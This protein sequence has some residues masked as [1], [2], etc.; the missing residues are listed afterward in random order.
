MAEFEN[1]D[2]FVLQA[3]ERKRG[4]NVTRVQEGALPISRQSLVQGLIGG[5]GGNGVGDR[6]STLSS[7]SV[8]AA[9]T[10]PVALGASG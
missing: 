2:E 7:R 4:L 10:V 9:N 1:I 3:E 5:D 6:D 8:Q